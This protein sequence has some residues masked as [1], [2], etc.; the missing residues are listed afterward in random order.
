MDRLLAERAARR[1]RERLRR[2]RLFAL[3]VLI[4]A[5]GAA[6][7]YGES[8]AREHGVRVVAIGTGN[9]IS[10]LVTAGRQ[11]ILV[12]AGDDATSLHDALDEELWWTQR[13][14]DLIFVAADSS[15]TSIRSS[16]WELNAKVRWDLDGVDAGGQPG[17]PA[18]IEL[19][20]DLTATMEIEP[21]GLSQPRDW[22]LKLERGGQRL[23]ILGGRSRWSF[24][25]TVDW[26]PSV[27]MVS[28]A[29]PATGDVRNS[30]VLV[31]GEADG[32]RTDQANHVRVVSG[33]AI[34]FRMTERGIEAE[35]PAHVSDALSAQRDQSQAVNESAARSAGRSDP[36]W[37]RL[38]RR[39]GIGWAS[40]WVRA[41]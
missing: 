10:T 37:S 12:V 13:S 30:V 26:R 15:E 4:G 36:G 20:H 17:L 39:R 24:D 14:L 3:G 11:R 16:L 38:H 7:L 22:M 18:R 27:A 29:A 5:L 28:T 23:A 40:A 21:G 33:N 2:L 25:R 8:A 1:E 34:T 31:P 41:A 19:K 9:G 32:E 6:V 35:V